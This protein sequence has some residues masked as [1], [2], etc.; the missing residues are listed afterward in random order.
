LLATIGSGDPAA[1]ILITTTSS[2][3][4]LPQRA[5]TTPAH[6]AAGP[7]ANSSAQRISNQRRHVL[8]VEGARSPATRERRVAKAVAELLDQDA[9][10]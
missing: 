9:Q 10:G 2:R 3:T 8:S 5:A 7:A 1:Q 4:D 6:R